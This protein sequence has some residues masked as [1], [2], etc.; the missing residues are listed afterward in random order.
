MQ[1]GALQRQNKQSI[2]T[3][4]ILN[5]LLAPFDPSLKDLMYAFYLFVFLLPAFALTST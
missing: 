2:F 5:Y 1:Q 4:S 3:S